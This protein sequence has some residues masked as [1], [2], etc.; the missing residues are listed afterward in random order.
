[1]KESL[2]KKIIIKERVL[3]EQRDKFRL[4]TDAVYCPAE[5]NKN[6][7]SGEIISKLFGVKTQG[8]FR[9]IGSKS[10]PKYI[11][12]YTTGK[13]LFWSDEF[14]PSFGLFLYYGDNKHPG[15][16]LHETN[17]HG[18]AILRNIFD[19]ACSDDIN[20]RKRIP[21][22]FIVKG[23]PE[24]GRDI[25]YIGLA[26]PGTNKT[27]KRNW[28]TAIWASDENGNRFQNYKALFTVLDT[29]DGSRFSPNDASVDLRWLTDIQN[30]KT[31]E[32]VYAPKS[33][34]SYIEKRKFEALL[35]QILVSHVKNKDE[36]MP[37]PETED[38]AML[39]CLQNYF[40]EKD[41]GYSFEEFANHMVQ[42]LDESVLYI[43]TTRKYK[44]GG[45]DGEG[46]YRIFRTS[47]NEIKIPFLVQA[48]CYKTNVSLKVH[49]TA[50]IISRLQ[51]GHFGVIITTSYLSEQAYDEIL[52]DR[53]NLVILSG[54]NIVEYLHRVDIHTVKKL[55]DY[56][57]KSY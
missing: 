17:I 22:I 35:P 4:V 24:G 26:V 56:L 48:K 47:I 42:T 40:V 54:K 34:V 30:D 53:C 32:S 20:M 49:D 43:N 45:F 9:Y 18:N 29:K 33:W 11:V 23:G 41:R 27:E 28:L 7:F 12:I 50:R 21:P 8:G 31:L 25:Q 5:E 2:N 51:K 39:N 36:Q 6:N 13:E 38:M 14:D 55:I 16:E 44:D 1:M 15:T 57:K 52:K 46:E 3:P 19:F 37:A 10:S